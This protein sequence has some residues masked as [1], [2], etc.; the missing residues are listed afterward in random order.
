MDLSWWI[1]SRAVK[2]YL[3]CAVVVVVAVIG[4]DWFL[5]RYPGGHVWLILIGLLFFL[6]GRI[7]AFWLKDLYRCRRFYDLERYPEA[8]DSGNRFLKTLES[9]PWRRKLIYLTWSLYTWNVE[10]M[11]RNNL[12]ASFMMS[13]KFD[14]ARQE[15]AAAIALDPGYA[16]PFA[17]LAAIEAAVGNHAESKRLALIAEKNGYSGTKAEKLADRVSAVYAKI[18][19][20]SLNP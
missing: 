7:S 9:E 14:P 18:Q 5:V 3:L 10:A 2:Y 12:G 13:G 1:V 16:L 11:T 15:L 19:T 4:A 20:A 8:I 6:P 17:N